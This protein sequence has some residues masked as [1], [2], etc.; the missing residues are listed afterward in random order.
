MNK[1]NTNNSEPKH[2]AGMMDE[3]TSSSC[4]MVDSMNLH[5]LCL[6]N[7]ETSNVVNNNSNDSESTMSNESDASDSYKILESWF[8]ADD[9]IQTSQAPT[10]L[11]STTPVSLQRDPRITPPDDA[12]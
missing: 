4:G 3:S 1:S 12:K 10:S 7:D 5:R 8:E 9:Q 6:E 2:T 11:S